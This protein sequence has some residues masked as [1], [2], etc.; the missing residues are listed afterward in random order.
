MKMIQNEPFH[1]KNQIIREG[2]TVFQSK[3]LLKNS[4]FLGQCKNMQS[5]VIQFCPF[6]KIYIKKRIIYVFIHS[7]LGA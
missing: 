6:V 4:V 7:V 2:K 1:R 3:H 5:T